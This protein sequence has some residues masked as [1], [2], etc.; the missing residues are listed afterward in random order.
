MPW[1]I[2]WWKVP[3]ESQEV[4]VKL[5]SGVKAGKPEVLSWALPHWSTMPTSRSEQ[6]HVL[7]S[8]HSSNKKKNSDGSIGT[9]DSDAA[10]TIHQLLYQVLID[11]RYPSQPSL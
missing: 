11:T 7:E 2:L 4:R 5:G 6:E 9:T 3:R 10:L 1:H 8:S